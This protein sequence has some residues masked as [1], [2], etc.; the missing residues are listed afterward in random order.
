MPTKNGAGSKRARSRK[1]REAKEEAISWTGKVARRIK[2]SFK[3]L[4]G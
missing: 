1:A 4:V 2:K 3:K